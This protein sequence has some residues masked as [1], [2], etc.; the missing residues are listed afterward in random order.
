[1]K[2]KPPVKKIE[3]QNDKQLDAFIAKAE[4]N[5]KKKQ[6]PWHKAEKDKMKVFNLRLS[7]KHFLMLKFLADNTHRSSMQK[8][9]LDNLEPF[10]ENES[11]KLFK[12]RD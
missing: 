6:A 11:Q 10:L 7:E 12:N 5:S 3:Q 9:C 4:S 8:I 2:S 1:M